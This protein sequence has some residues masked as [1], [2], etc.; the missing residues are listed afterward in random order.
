MNFFTLQGRPLPLSEDIF[1]KKF[2]IKLEKRC[3]PDL[4]QGIKVLLMT[5]TITE[6]TAVMGYLEP[7]NGHEKVV[8]TLV[9][10][11]SFFYVGKY[12]E[13]PVAVAMTAYGKSQQGSIEV[14]HFL[15]GI[16][17]IINPN[18]II[19]IGICYGMDPSEVNP[20]DIIVSEKV[21]DA[22][23]RIGA[24][25]H[26]RG[27]DYPAS[28]KLLG[29]FST[30]KM[31]GFEMKRDDAGNSVKVKTGILIS[32][33]DLVDDAKY[34]ELLKRACNEPDALGGEMEGAGIMSFAYRINIKAIIIKA[35]GDYGDGN[36][37][38]MKGWKEF[39]AH[40][41]ARYV[42]FIMKKFPGVLT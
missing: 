30:S 6:L 24:Q 31:M 11:S 5:A 18:Y 16:K 25:P 29:I 3:T 14:L 10:D 39:A 20:A 2:D 38:G 32:R 4:V 27:N 17:S 33:P 26:T 1:P 23:M 42:H 12:G 9:N 34:K 13:Y 41:A 21:C 19:A 22:A 28:R 15:Y 40:A 36:K 37:A 8:M 7:R 35:I